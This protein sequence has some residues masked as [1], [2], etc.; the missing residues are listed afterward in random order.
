MA[1]CGYAAYYAHLNLEESDESD[2]QQDTT[3]SNLHDRL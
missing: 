3:I 2:Q 1:A